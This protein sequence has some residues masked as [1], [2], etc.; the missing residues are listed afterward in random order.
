MFYDEELKQRKQLGFPPYQ[1][2][3]LVKLRGKKENRVKEVSNALFNRLNKYS[4]NNKAIKIVSVNPGQPAKLRGNFY[5]QI[6]IK[7]HSSGKIVKFLK[8]HLKKFSHS[9][10]IVTIDVDP[11]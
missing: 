10:I 7:A 3:C 5:W 11:I 4:K 9:G 6:L 1:H 8:L 2:L